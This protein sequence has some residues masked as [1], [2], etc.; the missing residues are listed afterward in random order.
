LPT[1]QVVNGFVE[2]GTERKWHELNVPSLSPL[3][4]IGD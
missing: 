1:I 2:N 4:R 3:H